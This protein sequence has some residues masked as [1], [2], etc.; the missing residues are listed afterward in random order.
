MT[1]QD[2]G[3]PN[4]GEQPPPPSY[5]QEP[6]SPSHGQE[7]PPPPYGSYIPPAYGAAPSGGSVPYS[8]TAAMGWGWRR[9][10]QNIGPLIITGLIVFG[11]Q[12][13]FGI[14]GRGTHDSTSLY[15]LV[16]AASF[17]VSLMIAAGI[18]RASLGVTSG[19]RFDT[20]KVF[21]ADQLGQVI[22]A[23]VITAILTVI[24]LF[25]LVLPGLVVL[26]FTQYVYYFVVDRGQGGIEA[27]GSSF[28]FVADNL[29]ATLLYFLLSIAVIILGV[30]CLL[31]GVLV[32]IPVVFLGQAYTYR[33]LSGGA[34]AD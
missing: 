32:A 3:T 6:A 31:V 34:V 12:V 29:G 28:R 11:I 16:Q 15:L 4:E 8:A 19:E 20:A 7:S 27:I 18:V 2:A 9:F 25:L 14:V 5:G 33:K 13:V 21:S 30:I 10:T 22:V 26:F 1:D 23:A 17:V 24:G